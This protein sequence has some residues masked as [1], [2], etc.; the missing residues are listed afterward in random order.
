M[1]S[2]PDI[3]TELP[4]QIVDSSAELSDFGVRGNH[5]SAKEGPLLDMKVLLSSA[6]STKGPSKK[7]VRQAGKIGNA[8][9]SDPAVALGLETCQRD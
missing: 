6:R 2:R 9:T 5:L 1:I 7:A 8:N 4:T 3:R